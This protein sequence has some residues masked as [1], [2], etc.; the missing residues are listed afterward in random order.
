MRWWLAKGVD[1]FRLNVINF[2]SKTPDYPE[3]KH[4]DES[5][6][7]DGSPYFIN[8]PR[9]HEYL[10]EMHEKVLKNDQIITIGDCPGKR[11][12]SSTTKSFAFL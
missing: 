8:G 9:V 12:I 5:Q 2:I 7:T 10:Q 3:G 1:G 11:T 6:C 4:H